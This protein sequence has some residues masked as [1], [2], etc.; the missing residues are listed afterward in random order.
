M[1]T[2]SEL[3]QPNGKTLIPYLFD[4]RREPWFNP[5]TFVTLQRRPSGFQIRTKWQKLLR[6]LTS[7]SGELAASIDLGSWAV[8]SHKL[9]RRRQTYFQPSTH[10]IYH[11]RGDSY[12]EYRTANSQSKR[13]IPMGG[14]VWAPTDACIPISAM[15]QPDGSLYFSGEGRMV[16]SPGPLPRI[17]RTFHQYIQTLQAWEQ[18]LLD[19]VELK[20]Q[21]YEIRSQL[22]Q[23]SENDCL[24]AVSDGSQRGSIISFGW[25]VG[26]EQGIEFAEHSGVGTGAPT[27]HRAEAW[28]MLSACLFIYHVYQYTA[29]YDQHCDTQTPLTFMSDNNG[30]IVR[31]QKRL[32]YE[33]V[34]PNAT[35]APDWDLVEQIT[36]MTKRMT[37]TRPTFQW[38][39]GHQDEDDPDLSVAARYNIRAD[40]LAGITTPSRT[41]HDRPFIIVPAEKCTLAIIHGHYSQAIRDGYTLPAFRE[42][43]QTRY[44]WTSTQLKL[45]DWAIFRRASSNI[46]ESQIQ[47]L[48]VIHDKLPTNSELAKSNPLQDDRCHYCEERETFFHLCRCANEVADKFRQDLIEAVTEYMDARA[49]PAV[50]QTQ[51]MLCLRQSL[52]IPTRELPHTTA[53]GCCDELMS[54]G[55]RS[56]LQ[57]FWSQEWQRLY[58]HAAS[59]YTLETPSNTIEFLAGLMQLLW[60]RQLQFWKSHLE[61][62]SSSDGV[63]SVHLEDKLQQYRTK[64]RLLHAQRAQCLHGHQETYFHPDV[65]AFLQNA[66]G[67]QMRAYLY[68]YEKAIQS[69]IEL[70]KSQQTRSIF[71]FPG[72]QHIRSAFQRNRLARPSTISACGTAS[73]AEIHQVP[74]TSR[75]TRGV[76][77]NN[78]KHTRWRN[79]PASVRTLPS[80]FPWKPD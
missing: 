80:F 34:Y 50:F 9:R 55:P 32:E 25:V 39:R 35:L 18:E 31:L 30:L 26:T 54:L 13:F 49:T 70:A 17:P 52:D 21:P 28:G 24:L 58:V 42:Y 68:H 20:Y 41:G 53:T 63:A 19:G 2:V 12:C 11:W 47:L 3:L 4:C 5:T 37:S 16:V 27:S 75:M 10:A 33:V 6:Q 29:G 51:F 59:Y 46:H 38:I 78:R 64:I 14:T 71:T 76:A 67:T 65:D 77:F 61:H 7:T 40:I 15:E 56:I 45:I 72:F 74:I 57:G 79:S 73:P 66:T 43:L 36:A 23:F 1:T 44:Q 69:S 22:S 60:K 8:P 48:K 62:I